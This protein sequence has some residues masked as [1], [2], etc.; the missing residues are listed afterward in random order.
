MT[1]VAAPSYR[2]SNRSRPIGVQWTTSCSLRHMPHGGRILLAVLVVG[3][4]MPSVITE[5]WQVG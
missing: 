4:V 2:R 1:P 3:F 5:P